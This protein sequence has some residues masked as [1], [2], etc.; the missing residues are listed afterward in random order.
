MQKV[1]YIK[2]VYAKRVISDISIRRIMQMAV[3][4][5]S[6]LRTIPLFNGV[7]SCEKSYRCYRLII[8]IE[9]HYGDRQ[10]FVFFIQRLRIFKNGSVFCLFPDCV[11]EIV[12]A[13]N[14]A[15][16]IAQRW[17]VS[18]EEIE[19]LYWQIYR[20]SQAQLCGLA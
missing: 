18:A 1:V 17:R 4:G 10:R 15:R 7:I 11:R 2:N 19:S 13:A 16:C 9:V 3:L 8:P 14:P 6:W 12:P 5:S 20:F